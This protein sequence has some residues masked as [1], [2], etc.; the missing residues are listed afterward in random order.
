MN[1]PAADLL[2]ELTRLGVT[3]GVQGDR[4]WFE[5]KSA[6]GPDLVARLRQHKILL[7]AIVGSALPQC[8]RCRSKEFVDVP[9]H[10]GRSLRRDCARCGQFLDFPLWYGRNR[11]RFK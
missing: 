9:I 1:S 10:G 2:A 5:P 8:D 3:V 4:L 6:L 11:N 7:M